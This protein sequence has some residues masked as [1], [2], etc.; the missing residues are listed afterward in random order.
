MRPGR[1]M[2]DGHMQVK[3]PEFDGSGSV[4]AAEKCPVEVRDDEKSEHC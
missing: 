4:Q 3:E 1:G 2:P